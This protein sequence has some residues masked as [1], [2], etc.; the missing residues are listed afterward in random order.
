MTLPSP[1]VRSA[2]IW[3]ADTTSSTGSSATGA[4]AWGIN[5][6]A[7]GPFHAP[8]ARPARAGTRPVRDPARIASEL[9]HARQVTGPPAKISG[10]NGGSNAHSAGLPAMNRDEP[11]IRILDMQT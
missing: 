10:G 4:K 2:T 11:T 3:I 1:S 6:S 9:T 7:A 8:S 5:D